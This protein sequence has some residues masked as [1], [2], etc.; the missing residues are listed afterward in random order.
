MRGRHVGILA[1]AVILSATLVVDAPAATEARGSTWTKPV[2]LDGAGGA[3]GRVR[4]F[5]GPDTAAVRF[6]GVT[7]VFYS[8]GSGGRAVLRHA[9]FARPPVFETLDGQGGAAG[10]TTDGVGRDV[11]AAVYGGQIHVFYRDATTGDVR[12]AWFDGSRWRFRTLDGGSSEG[13]RIVADVGA[14]SVAT[15]YDGRLEVA[16]LDETNVDVRRASYD[17]TTWSFSTVD[18]DSIDGGH[19]VH[20]VGFNL[21]TGV[22]GGSLH[23]LY[24]ECDPAYDTPFGHELGWVREAV[25]DGGSWTYAQAFRVSTILDEKTLALGVAATDNVT[26]AYNTTTD[27]GVP[28]LRWRRWDGAV[29]SDSS[30]LTNPPAG[31]GEVTAPALFSIAGG[32]V[33]LAFSD[34]S[35]GYTAYFTWSGGT[36]SARSSDIVGTPSSTVVVGG[37]PRIFWGMGDDPP[38]CCDYLLLRTSR[39]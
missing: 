3:D 5:I 32:I 23:L 39:P 7:H 33:T 10:R 16:Y 27:D 28:R 38:G 30:V 22:W 25:F 36:V 17:G 15:V 37:V 35:G 8:A 34:R 14:A 11:S 9:A 4:K 29:W 20:E 31:Y 6:G 12:H 26:V 21:A 2:V 1:A 19:T 24:Y 18:G 13:G